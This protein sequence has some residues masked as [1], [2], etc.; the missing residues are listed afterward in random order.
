ME[1]NYSILEQAEVFGR[2]FWRS[3]HCA[4]STT[5]LLHLSDWRGADGCLLGALPQL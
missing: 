4:M 5:T 3:W 2:S 1:D